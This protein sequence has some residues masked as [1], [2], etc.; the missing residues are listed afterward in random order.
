MRG[1]RVLCTSV[2]ALEALTV[3]LAIPVALA[4]GPVDRRGQWAAA[5]AVLALI[6]MLAIGVVTR[7]YGPAVGWVVQVLV[8]ASGFLIP[9]MFILGVIF[10]LLWYAAVRFGRQTD[11]PRSDPAR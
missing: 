9:A 4:L 10:A 1:T 8:L 3:L 7:P 2:L 11:S 5:L 6:C